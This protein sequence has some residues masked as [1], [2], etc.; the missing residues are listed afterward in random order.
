MLPPVASF[1]HPH[2]LNFPISV[3]AARVAS[4]LLERKAI[5]RGAVLLGKSSSAVQA[6]AS[7]A[8]GRRYMAL[9]GNGYLCLPRNRDIRII[10]RVN[11]H[12]ELYLVKGVVWID[13]VLIKRGCDDIALTLLQSDV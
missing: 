10:V 11:I 12:A 2:R 13:I 1:A 6:K 7:K 3:A 8:N 5:S 9:I 4:A